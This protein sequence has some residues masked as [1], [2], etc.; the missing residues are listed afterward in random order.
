MISLRCVQP[1]GFLPLKGKKSKKYDFVNVQ[2]RSSAIYLPLDSYDNI[3]FQKTYKNKPKNKSVLYAYNHDFG[4]HHQ[5]PDFK[6]YIGSNTCLNYQVLAS[7]ISKNKYIQESL[8][9]KEKETLQYIYVQDEYCKL[10]QTQNPFFKV[11]HLW[12][13]PCNA[14]VQPFDCHL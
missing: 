7:L 5:Y 14:I 11:K 4:E 3:F 1:F 10:F 12:L 13:Y 9:E 2:M 8:S 6:Y